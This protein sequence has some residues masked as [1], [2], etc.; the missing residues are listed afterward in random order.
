MGK[1]PGFFTTGSTPKLA[2][3]EALIE[4]NCSELEQRTNRAWRELTVS[5]DYKDLQ[6]YRRYDT[7]IR[8]YLH[9]GVLTLASGSGDKLEVWTGSSWEDWLS[10]K[11]EGRNNDYWLVPE[12]GYLYLNAYNYERVHGVRVSYRY[13]ESAGTHLDDATGINASDATLIVDSTT[14]FASTG[15][16]RIEDEDITYT[17]K[18][19]TTFTGCGRGAYGTTAASHSDNVEVYT[20]PKQ[21][22]ALVAKMVLLDLYLGDHYSVLFPEGTTGSLSLGQSLEFLRKEVEDEIINRLQLPVFPDGF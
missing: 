8:V 1:A 21:I 13:N 4:E 3:L 10:S 15:Y 18:T 11:T 14:G 2:Q 19:A 16:L 20:V 7:G 5:N 17:G 9:L 12:Q 22:E 6:A